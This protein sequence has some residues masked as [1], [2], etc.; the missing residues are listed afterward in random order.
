MSLASALLLAPILAQ[1]PAPAP[2]RLVL[3]PA[4]TGQT[5]GLR[6][7][8]LA[9]RRPVESAPLELGTVALHFSGSTAVVSLRP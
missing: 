4:P 2:V 3:R 5:G 9:L 6:A 1:H 7:F 8:T